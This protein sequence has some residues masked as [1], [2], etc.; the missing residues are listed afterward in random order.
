MSASELI[1]Y[2][3]EDGKTEVQLKTEDGS[4]SQ[5]DMAELFATTKQ[6][7]SLHIQN[8]LEDRELPEPAVVKEYLTTADDGKRYKTKHY[9]LHMIL[10]VGYR[11]R[12]PRGTQFRQWA[13]RH[14]AEYLVKGFVMDDERLKNPGGWDYFDELLARI[15]DIRASEKQFYQKV[16]DLF[17]LSADY[18]ISGVSP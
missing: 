2:R 10:A 5:G 4:L 1:V 9:N 8:I 18:E 16:R 7:I 13:T 11:V 17:A 14:L 3:T 6:N 15:R 12:S